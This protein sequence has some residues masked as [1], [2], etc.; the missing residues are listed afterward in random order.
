MSGN[1]VMIIFIGAAMVLPAM[2]SSD[3]SFEDQQLKN[4]RVVIAKK[5]KEDTLRKL[6]SEKGIRWPVKNIFIRAFKKEAAME[7]WAKNSGNGVYKL[8][9]TYPI[10]TVSGTLGPKRRE[11]DLQTPEGFYFINDFN[12]NS[13]FFLSLG[14]N[15]PNASDRIKAAD[16]NRPGGAIYIHGNCV[17]IGCM[18]IQDDGIKELYWLAVQAKNN[19]QNRISVH[20]F[21]FR[22]G[23]GNMRLAFEKYS[24]NKALLSFWENLQTGYNWFEKRKNLPTVSVDKKGKYLFGE[25]D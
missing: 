14:I 19:G 24:D 9:K 2:K 15:Y 16:K 25:K 3:N 4:E 20:V 21:P 11:G 13:T 5:E 18:P 1:L 22:M 7:V 12:P 17:S 6:C 8:L 10:C 23:G